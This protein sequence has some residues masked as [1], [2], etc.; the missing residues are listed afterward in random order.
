MTRRETLSTMLLGATSAIAATASA[1]GG[2]A[3]AGGARAVALRGP[4]FNQDS[5]DFFFAWPLEEMTGEGVDRWVDRLAEAGVGTA[6]TCVCAMC[7]N[8]A[9][10]VWEPHWARCDA[11]G[12]DD[13]PALASLS[14]ES[15]AS[16]RKWVA[17]MK[18]LADQGVNFHERAYARM[19]THGIAS[20]ATIRMNDLHDCDQPDSPLL[21]SFFLDQRE[22]GLL[23]VP[24]R[25]SG[26]PERALDWGRED[27]RDHYM[28]LVREVLTFRGL[29]GLELDWMR[30]GW[31]FRIG[32]ELEG[33]E[34][35]TEWIREVRGLCD[36]L[37]RREGRP[38]RLGCRVPSTPETAR[39]LGLDG[40]RWA[41]EGLIDLLTPTPFWATCEFGMPMETW[42]RLLEGTGCAL[43]GGLEVLYRP[44]PGGAFKMMSP[45]LARGA[46]TAVLSS[47]ADHV[48]LFNYFG[49][50]QMDNEWTRPVY[51]ETLSA[52]RS[53]EALEPLART[54]GV[55]YRDTIAPGEEY[56]PRLPADGGLAIFR[57]MTGPS[58]EGRQ[59]E[60]LLE[61]EPSGDTE[62]AAPSVRVNA[63]EC[64]APVR[65]GKCIVRYPVP[66]EALT[67]EETVIE[68]TG[69]GSRII[70]V[71]VAVAG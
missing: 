58:P 29:E 31:H 7:T 65:E 36:E 44:W 22:R 55:T 17:G 69:A 57:L 30:F 41:R 32:R 9:S 56:A 40:V 3:V 43:A 10:R 4:I 62:P 67:D 15:R 60:V 51:D 1:D 49:R 16:A 19:R 6:L 45:E 70:R 50:G 54:H 66:A 21:S 8:Y 34:I 13:Q 25:L 48:Y 11:D 5:T 27:V 38:I 18:S 53:L 63:T 46:A 68:A 39:R 71:E 26:W 35:L 42:K 52:M 37:A 24:Y 14:P 12:P 64:P 33:G 59:V 28:A 23:R 20:W 2:H 47:G 61:L